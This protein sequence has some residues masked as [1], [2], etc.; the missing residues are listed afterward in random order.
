MGLGVRSLDAVEDLALHAV[1]DLP[2]P[3]HQL[4]HLVDGVLRVFLEKKRAG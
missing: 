2:S 4:Q 1:L 3:H